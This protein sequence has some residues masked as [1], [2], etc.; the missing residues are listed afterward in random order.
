MLEKQAWRPLVPAAWRCGASTHWREV[1]P[2]PHDFQYLL[3]IN[4]LRLIPI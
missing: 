2:A 3:P 4:L 1:F